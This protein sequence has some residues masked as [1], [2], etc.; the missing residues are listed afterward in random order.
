MT[1]NKLTYKL[2]DKRQMINRKDIKGAK[3]SNDS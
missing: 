1:E 3:G 2:P